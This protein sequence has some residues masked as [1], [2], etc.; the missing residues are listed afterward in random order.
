MRSKQS[1]QCFFLLSM[2]ACVSL[3]FCEQ[4]HN[5][6][7]HDKSHRTFSTSDTLLKQAHVFLIL[8][9]QERRKNIFFRVRVPFFPSHAP[10]LIYALFYPKYVRQ[11]FKKSLIYSNYNHK[12]D[13]MELLQD[14]KEWIDC[15]KK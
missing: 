7:I 14:N 4:I 2:C 15:I 3:F 5:S 8:S 1:T 12:Y 10:N 9:Q 13:R 11:K 6:S